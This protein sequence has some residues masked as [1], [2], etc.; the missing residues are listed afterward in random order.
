MLMVLSISFR[1]I[2]QVYAP[3]NWMNEYSKMDVFVLLIKYGNK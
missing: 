1:V 3:P 2:V